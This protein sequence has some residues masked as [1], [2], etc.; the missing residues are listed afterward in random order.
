MGD[1]DNG[2]AAAVKVPQDLQHVG[3]GLGIQCA[4]RLVGHDNGGMGGDGPGNGHPLL[5]AAGHFGGLVV[6]PVVHLHLAEGLHGH[7]LPPGG[8]DPLIDQRKGHVFQG[9]QLL[10]EVIALKDKADLPVPDVGQLLVAQPCHVGSV[11][12]VVP[13]GRHIQTAQH[14]HEGGLSAAGGAHNGDEF[15]AVDA[16]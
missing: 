2:I 9:V 3:A 14:I 1:K 8:R 7:F 10:N 5:L 4:G 13:V 15:A 11:Q 16:Q 6:G 12:M